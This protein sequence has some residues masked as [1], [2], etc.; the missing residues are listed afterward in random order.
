MIKVYI[1]SPYTIGDV[2]QNVKNVRLQVDTVNE[3]MNNG[4][5]PFSP[6]YSHFQHMIHPRVYT[7][8]LNIDFEW[9]KSC[10]CLLRLDGE[11]SGADKEVKVAQN[12]NIPVFYSIKELYEHY[13]IYVKQISVDKPHNRWKYFLK[14][15]IYF[16]IGLLIATGFIG[17]TRDIPSLGA[18]ILYLVGWFRITD[19]SDIFNKK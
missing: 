16:V 4:F 18:L 14:K 6:L 19:L 3:L 15:N 10:D 13:G 8:W 5:A 17:I 12:A 11:S 1:A 2:A 9:V 7:D